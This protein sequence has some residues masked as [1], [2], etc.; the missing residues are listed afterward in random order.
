MLMTRVDGP[1]DADCGCS[2]APAVASVPIACSLDG[3]DMPA[4]IAD[5]QGVLA[6]VEARLPLANGVRLEFSPG[7]SMTDVVRLAAA[8]NDC[9]PFFGFAVTID[10]R[11]FALEVTAPSDGQHL[12]AGLF[13]VASSTRG[14]MSD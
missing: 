11:G 13:G 6:L 2:T 9:C 12:L 5:W 1:G 14:P 8:E 7:V 4:R 10:G 3:G